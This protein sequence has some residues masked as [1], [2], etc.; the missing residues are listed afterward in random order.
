MRDDVC[1][2]EEGGAEELEKLWL[3][4]TS[5]CSTDSIPWDW[6]LVFPGWMLFPVGP[7]FALTIK[8]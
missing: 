7:A 6:T 4:V 2:S 5:L 3:L 8:G 1:R